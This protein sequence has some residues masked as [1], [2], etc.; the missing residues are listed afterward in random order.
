MTQRPHAITRRRL[1]NMSRTVRTPP[2]TEAPAAE[3]QMS[4]SV[5]DRLPGRSSEACTGARGDQHDHSIAGLDDPIRAE[6]DE[7]A[8]TVDLRLDGIAIKC[9]IAAISLRRPSFGLAAG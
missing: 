3:P 9:A 6:D 2:L 5:L 4:T 7:P 1:P 8:N